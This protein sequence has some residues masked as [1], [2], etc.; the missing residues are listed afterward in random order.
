[1]LLKWLIYDNLF[2]R[3]DFLPDKTGGC[4]LNLIPGISSQGK[5]NLY[6][7]DF[8]KTLLRG[9]FLPPKP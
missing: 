2:G 9:L 5:V 6:Q 3:R 8:R 1:M 4:Y 7:L